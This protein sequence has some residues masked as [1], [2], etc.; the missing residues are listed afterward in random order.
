MVSTQTTN[1]QSQAFSRQLEEDQR[2][3]QSVNPQQSQQAQQTQSERAVN[4]VGSTEQA[5]M[6]ARDEAQSAL[7]TVNVNGQRV[8]TV[9]NTTA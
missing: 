5:R 3:Q 6:E 4:E 8:G 9:V 2:I 1:M 7:P